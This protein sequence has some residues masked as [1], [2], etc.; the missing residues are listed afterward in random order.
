MS[1]NDGD[2][3]RADVGKCLADALDVI[4]ATDDCVRLRIEISPADASDLVNGCPWGLR[5]KWELE[6]FAGELQ[7]V[8]HIEEIS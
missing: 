3:L 7:V 8:R 4:A 2:R 6:I 1:D 5:H